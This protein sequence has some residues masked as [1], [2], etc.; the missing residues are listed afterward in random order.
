MSDGKH[1]VK[2]SKYSLD[3]DYIVIPNE[4][5]GLGINGKVLGC[6]NRKT[7]EKCA[8]KILQDCPKARREVELHLHGSGSKHI[9][10]IKDIYENMF[11]GKR[12]LVIIMEC[13]EGGELFNRIQERAETGFTEREASQVI[14]SIGSAIKYLHDRNIAHRDVKPENILYTSKG[15]DA[16]LKL[17]D[18][19][20]AKQVSDVHNTLQTPCFTPYYVAPEVLGSEKYDKSCDLWSLGVIM[21]IILCGYPP[22]YSHHG[23]PISPGMKKRIKGGE[24]SFPNPEWSAVSESAKNLVKRLLTT[25]P[26]KR[27]TINEFMSNAWVSGKVSVPQTPLFSARVLKEDKE[28]WPEVQEEMTNALATMRVDYDQVKQMKTLDTANNKLLNKR[29]N[30]RQKS[31]ET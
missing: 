13:M 14:R 2:I 8:L 31:A 11:R 18:F 27:I 7:S 23:L 24:Y 19:G 10:E 9:V 20:F 26:E 4:V 15:D 12:C 28:Q 17:T 21:Y 3:R 5:L 1:V 22:F 30:K 29:K 6:T 25:D 16:T